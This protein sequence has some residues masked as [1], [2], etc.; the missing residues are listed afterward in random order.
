MGFVLA[1]W[2]FTNKPSRAEPCPLNCN[3]GDGR[4]KLRKASEVQ[5]KMAE[6]RLSL[7]KFKPELH[8]NIKE[9]IALISSDQPGGFWYIHGP[10]GVGKTYILTAAVNEA[11]AQLRSGVYTTA[12]NMMNNLRAGF[13]AKSVGQQEPALLRDI[14][15]TTILCIDELGR[16]RETDYTAEKIFEIIDSRYIAATQ[17]SSNLAAK[18]TIFAGNYPLDQLDPYLKSRLSDRN[19][20]VIN[21]SG[22]SDRRGA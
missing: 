18:L 17:Y 14:K 13:S 8:S 19:S 9:L 4:L 1:E 2:P 20:K 3:K 7:G 16:E 10:N 22:T 15:N 6:W 12:S 5:G 11:V 21:L